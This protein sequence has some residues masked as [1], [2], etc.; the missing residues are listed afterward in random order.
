MAG[1]RKAKKK[2]TKRSRRSRRREPDA[3][4]P[5]PI[6]DRRVMEGMMRQLLPETGGMETTLDAAQEIMHQAFEADSPKR[7]V[8]T[9]QNSEKL[10]NYVA[11]A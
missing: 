3:L 7:R 9:W 8:A 2:S 5:P 6:P 1:K 4:S 11:D 10:S